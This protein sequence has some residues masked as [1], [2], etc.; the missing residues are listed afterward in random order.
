MNADGRTVTQE[1]GKE[2]ESKQ[3]QLDQATATVSVG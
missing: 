3:I 1:E 2:D